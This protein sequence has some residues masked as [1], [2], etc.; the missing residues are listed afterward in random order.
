MAAGASNLATLTPAHDARLS[1]QTEDHVHEKVRSPSHR[2]ATMLQLS[3]A[4]LCFKARRTR[5]TGSRPTQSSIAQGAEGPLPTR[6]A[7]VRVNTPMFGNTLA[8]LPPGHRASVRGHCTSEEPYLTYRQ[9]PCTAATLRKPTP[10]RNLGSIKS[11][12]VPPPSGQAH[13]AQSEHTVPPSQSHADERQQWWRARNSQPQEMSDFYHQ[14]PAQMDGPETAVDHAYTAAALGDVTKTP[15]LPN[16][17][18]AYAVA[19][20]FPPAPYSQYRSLR[21][22]SRAA[23]FHHTILPLLTYAHIPA[24]LFLDYNVIF[25]L[26]QIALYP[27]NLQQSGTRAAWWISLGIYAACVVIWL[28]GVVFLY[29][30][31]WSYARRWTV[32]QPLVMPIYL[33]SPAFTRTAMKDYSLYSLLYRAHASASRRDSLIESFWY[34]SQNW[35]T[36]LTLIPRASSRSSRWSSIGRLVRD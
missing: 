34:Y 36:V 13:A 2:T 28:V 8:E 17:G 7:S 21:L 9:A 30:R 18:D 5:W 22:P 10:S 32:P 16:L 6:S 24:T 31:V 19:P 27:D 26:V 4:I 14:Q 12:N 35:P 20:K 29:E 3:R 33:S 23:R 1:R 25:A 15:Q 11:T